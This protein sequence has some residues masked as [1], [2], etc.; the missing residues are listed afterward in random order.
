MR[1]NY[2]MNRKDERNLTLIESS[3]N[4]VKDEVCSKTVR[5]T[6]PIIKKLIAFHNENAEKFSVKDLF[7]K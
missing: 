2:F 3:K 7:K 6:N 4:E 1:Y 5:Q